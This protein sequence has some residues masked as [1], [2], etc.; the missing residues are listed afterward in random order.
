MHMIHAYHPPLLP[1]ANTNNP[2][3]HL[4]DGG[5]L[6]PPRY[7]S[8]LM[9][10]A[11][12]LT[13]S[14]SSSPAI[15]V[16][17]AYTPHAQQIVQLEKHPV[18]EVSRCCVT[19]DPFVRKDKWTEHR[20]PCFH[21]SVPGRDSNEFSHCVAP[22]RSSLSALSFYCSRSLHLSYTATDP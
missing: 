3:S 18:T 1:A 15:S 7:H 12:R 11:L 13:P 5:L 9:V 4:R 21:S 17:A 19:H 10:Q 6:S 22:P 16:A 14:T 8:C 2:P 20:P